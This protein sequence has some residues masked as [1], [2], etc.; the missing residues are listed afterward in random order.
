MDI[1][2]D[3]VM[4]MIKVGNNE[5]KLLEVPEL[6]R[7]KHIRQNSFL[8]L[9]YPGAVHTRFEHSIGVF[10]IAT[11]IFDSLRRLKPTIFSGDSAN[12]SYRNKRWELW[13]NR[14]RLAALLHDVGHGPLSHMS[15][16]M[17]LRNRIMPRTKNAEDIS[18]ETIYSEQYEKLP[19]LNKSVKIHE[20]I[21][22]LKILN[23]PKRTKE[24][25][26]QTLEIDSADLEDEIERISHLAFGDYHSEKNKDE[27]PFWWAYE[28]IA[29]DF[30]ADRLEYLTRD[31][32][33]TGTKY[34]IVDLDRIINSGFTIEEVG[35]NKYRLFIDFIKGLGVSESVLVART[36]MY[37][38]VYL[39]ST[40]RS[41]SA[42]LMRSF[43]KVY[44]S[45]F[46][47]K[48][49][50]TKEKL[51]FIR[52]I[53]EMKD[54]SFILYL[55]S[56]ERKSNDRERLMHRIMA[57]DLYKKL[58]SKAYKYIKWKDLHPEVRELLKEVSGDYN[59]Y[60]LL[61]KCE[62]EIEKKFIYNKK[63]KYKTSPIIIDIP[64]VS[65]LDEL[66]SKVFFEQGDRKEKK[67]L[68]E[69]SKLAWIIK[70]MMRND[71]N[72]FVFYD[73]NIAQENIENELKDFIEKQFVSTGNGES[74][75]II[76]EIKSNA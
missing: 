5:Q 60:Y 33:Y 18:L 1:I 21:G 57:R 64:P 76:R 35:E 72:M 8:Y 70:D 17:L 16:I 53:M 3:P 73:R 42:M 55:M 45:M 34:G 47:E 11:R 20:W 15:E 32:H 22:S 75:D 49:I 51:D 38:F 25:I 41:A 71:W 50:I 31:S 74:A 23:S 2:S 37:P 68:E 69:V 59:K 61:K 29:G 44:E 26:K 6:N 19:T 27:T 54:Y 4:G 62:N 66:Q 67:S 28:V 7:L 63:N 30:D 13:R 24:I 48:D 40:A 14:V 12:P 46:K 9:V 10:H 36:Q 58:P 52:N 56:E 39:H 65:P 43:D